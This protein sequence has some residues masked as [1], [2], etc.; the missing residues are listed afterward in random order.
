[1]KILKIILYGLLS[2]LIVAYLAFLFVLPN[3]INL[4]KFNP[5]ITEIF[6]K[7]TGF[8]VNIKGLK[9]KTAWNLSCGTLIEK[10]DLK[11]PTGEKFAQINN[12]DVK[13]SLLPLLLGQIQLDKISAEKI[14]LN[15]E[16]EKNGRFLIDQYLLKIKEKNSKGNIYG[17]K[18]STNM[19][20]IKA[21]K[22]R[23]S[24]IN[25]SNGHKYS[26]RGSD[27]KISD[28]IFNKKIK[29]KSL[30]DLLLNNRKQVSYNINL[31]LKV[32]PVIDEKSKKFNVVDI[33]EEF[34][35]YNLSADIKT[36]VKISGNQ[37]SPKYEGSLDV[38]NLSSTIDGVLLPKSSLKLKLDGDK[39][40]IISDFYSGLNKHASIVGV[41]K[42][43]K[44]KYIDLNV[45]SDKT[46]IKNT[47]LIANALFKMFGINKLKGISADG[48]LNANFSIK[49]D[50]KTVQ[51]NGFL[52]IENANVIDK[53]HN[54][55]LKSINADLDFSK[56]LV[57]IKELVSYL[58]GKPIYVKGNIDKNANADILILAEKLNLKG[59]LLTVGQNQIL[60]DN[61][62][63]G[64]ISL[65][66]S[67]QG[68]LDKAIP[69]IDCNL[70]S[71]SL[72]SKR[73]KTKFMLE[74]VNFIATPKDKKIIGSAEISGLK[75]FPQSIVKAVSSPKILLDFD[76]K[77]IKIDKAILYLN[78]S[79]IFASGKITDYKSVNPNVD[80]TFKSS[81]LSSDI[82]SMLP[83]SYQSEILT[84]GVIPTLVKIKGSGKKEI[85]AQ[86]LANDK[87]HVT[88]IDIIGLKNKTSLLNLKVNLEG[89]NIKIQEAALYA[90]NSSK[91]VPETTNSNV[92]GS[93]IA[94]VKGD[95]NNLQNP[96]LNIEVSIPSQII[97]T[98]PTYSGATVKFKGDVEIV[99]PY[100]K[101]YLKGYIIVPSL[102]LPTYKISSKNS[103]LHFNNTSISVNCPE[104]YIDNSLISYNAVVENDFSKEILVKNVDFYANSI[105]LNT[106]APAFMKLVN[107]KH[108]TKTNLPIKILNGKG[109]VKKFKVGKIIAT[110]IISDFA[111]ENNH[112]KL[113]NLSGTAYLGKIAGEI[114]Y[115]LTYGVIQMEMQGR[116]LSAGP[117]IMALSDRTEDFQGQLDFDSNI[118]MKGYNRAQIIN[119]LKGST[120]FII[121]NG[122]MGTL[123]KL[124]H[125]LYAQNVLS[126][127]VFDTTLNVIARAVS[128][129]N[130]GYYKYLKGQLT[131]NNGW[132][133][134][135]MIKMSGP[136]M[137]MYITGR[138]EMANN[139]ANLTILGRLSNDV[140]KILGPIGDLSVSK[141]FSSIPK[142][143][144]IT[145]PMLRQ[146]TT[147]PQYENMSMIPD[148]TPKTILPT[149][150]FKVIIDGSAD[151]Q[152]AVKS[153]K[154]LSNPRLENG[155]MIINPVMESEKPKQYTTPD[156][157]NSLPD[158]K[159]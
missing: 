7:N 40:N 113:S 16:V 80:F 141:V 143:G 86:M 118:S 17:L 121:N 131:F 71:V 72:K 56:N 95:I 24:F 139:Y 69:K 1:M 116:G 106:L 8:F 58:D 60:E 147:S 6:E 79:K 43:G 82:K 37:K 55:H 75:I 102:N 132:A 64:V 126:N 108:E 3:L 21:K 136:S 30:G 109:S 91:E 70:N 42:A 34:Y 146:M 138:Y 36:V 83:K 44:N 5:Q 78:N 76:D 89:N 110:D 9:L 65:K 105:D 15:L 31:F 156:F 148:L 57:N 73:L 123:G 11:Y 29:I 81:L 137:S 94:S 85:S 23:I 88:L 54:V 155:S 41:L 12:L 127:N 119:N 61:D 130:T 67:L 66:A 112:L 46:D 27:L 19:P 18:L 128:V 103:G 104:F 149:K 87:N 25:I 120:N 50:F 159:K 151:A 4:D 134:I 77:E 122:K 96:D 13:L 150:E 100:K 157:V 68:R 144:E 90:L 142:I 52:K 92:I 125:L 129:K 38:K 10:T 45:K 33:F 153:F 28:F 145:A 51:S 111:M 26:L 158:L 115:D 117:A 152:N 133:Y 20:D 101:P 47:F 2:F 140:V 154:W 114:D 107:D 22:Y 84:S 97:A 93:K 63:A 53:L 99:G 59:F 39:I 124:E 62:V 98:L 32:F 49:S 48:N 74:K 135:G 14:F 35:N